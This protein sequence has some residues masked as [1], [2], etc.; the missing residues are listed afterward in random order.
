MRDAVEL[1]GIFSMVA[2]AFL[3]SSALGFAAL[4]VA[5]V[6]VASFGPSPANRRRVR[7]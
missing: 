2:A 1:V 3:L 5:L 4:G 7:R 6:I